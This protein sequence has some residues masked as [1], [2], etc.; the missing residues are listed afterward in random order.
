VFALFALQV[1]FSRWWLTRY[2]YG[3]AEWVWRAVTYLRVPTMR[4]SAAD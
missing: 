1:L 2:R 4:I 3:P